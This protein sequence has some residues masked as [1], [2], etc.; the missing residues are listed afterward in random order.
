MGCRRK[1]DRVA[2]VFV[3]KRKRD[4]AQ[5]DLI[6]VIDGVSGQDGWSDR[7]VVGT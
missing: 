1:D 6:V 2:N 4:G 5:Y 3:W 7:R